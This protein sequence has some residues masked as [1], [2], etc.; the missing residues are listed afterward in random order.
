MCYADF[1][2][3]NDNA[4][5]RPTRNLRSGWS[6]LGTQAAIGRETASSG[7][8]SGAC[9]HLCEPPRDAVTA[10]SYDGLIAQSRRT[11]RYATHHNSI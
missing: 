1:D 10:T 7:G 3:Y 9:R 2:M 11:L 8:L 6:S 5:L 4:E